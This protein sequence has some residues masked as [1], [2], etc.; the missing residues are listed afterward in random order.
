MNSLDELRSEGW[1]RLLAAARR[2]LE[3]DGALSGSVS[4]GAPSEEERRVIIGLTGRY[5]PED[6]KRLTVPLT[7]LDVFLTNRYTHGLRDVLAELGGPLRDRAGERRALDEERDRLLAGASHGRHSGDAWHAAWLEAIAVDGTATRLIRRGEGRLVTTAAQVLDQLPAQAMPLPVLAER[8]TGD[9]KALSA[10]SPLTLLVLRA[11]AL[12]AG[13][14]SVPGDRVGQRTLWE[15]AGVIVDDLASQVLVLN[16]PVLGQGPVA[17][18]LAEAARYGVPYRLTLHQ[19]TT[20]PVAL[21]NDPIFICENPA[22]LRAAATELGARSAPLICTEG[23][24]SAACHR[25]LETAKGELRWRAD[26]DW[27]GL[28]IMERAISRHRAAPWRMSAADYAAGLAESEST[29][30]SGTA[31]PSPWDVE[32][33]QL[34]ASRGWTVMEERLIPALLYDLNGEHPSRAPS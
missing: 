11:L 22:V 21:D 6:V 12:R 26:F 15:S 5:R 2:K 29:P 3:R 4:I 34:M 25:L 8:A 1:A 10:G 30:L 27:T 19:L 18:W 17:G 16:L 23:I 33:A 14:P 20:F 28:R 7:D 31:A 9:T 32:L 24:P 13:L